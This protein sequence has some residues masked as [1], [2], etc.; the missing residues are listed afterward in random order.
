MGKQQGRDS[1]KSIGHM[2][3]ETWALSKLHS[4]SMFLFVFFLISFFNI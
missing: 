2:G 1:T 3:Y 4:T